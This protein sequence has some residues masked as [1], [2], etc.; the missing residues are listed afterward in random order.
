MDCI[1][2]KIAS[3]AI[4]AAKLYED[5]EVVA[6]RDLHPQAPTHFLVIPRKHL[7]SLNDITD[8]DETLVG[9][10]FHA[11]KTLA[12]QEGIAATGFR[13]VFNTGSDGGQT[14]FHLHLHVLGG[15]QMTWPPG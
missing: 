10:M 14:V 7:T 4:P 6:F 9:H 1:F 11:A 12:E 8:H 5:P 15:R 13:T 2:C 3:G